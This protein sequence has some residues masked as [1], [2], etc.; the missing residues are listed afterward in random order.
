M[1]PAVQQP[2]LWHF[3]HLHPDSH[4]GSGPRQRAWQGCAGRS[5]AHQ[6]P[7]QILSRTR[8]PDSPQ[9]AAPDRGREAAP[10]RA[11]RWRC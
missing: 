5:A 8:Q 11:C 7:K 9:T 6:R 4:A 3:C 10:S 2:V 1:Q